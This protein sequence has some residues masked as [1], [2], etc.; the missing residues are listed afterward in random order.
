MR[1]KLLNFF[2]KDLN[3]IEDRISCKD[4]VNVYDAEAGT[5]LS[6]MWKNGKPASDQDL[7]YNEKIYD[8]LMA[9]ANCLIENFDCS[10]SMGDCQACNKPMSAYYGGC[11]NYGGCDQPRAIGG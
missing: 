9:V 1:S 5:F 6:R 11:V 8:H 10:Y 2:L 3:R 4:K 7:I